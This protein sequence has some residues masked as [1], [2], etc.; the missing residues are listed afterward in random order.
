MSAH[1]AQ[2]DAETSQLQM[3]ATVGADQAK[4]GLA[5]SG[6]VVAWQLH[7][8]ILQGKFILNHGALSSRVDIIH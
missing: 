2:G 8:Q 3:I 6:V 1:N 4:G 7:K 5:S